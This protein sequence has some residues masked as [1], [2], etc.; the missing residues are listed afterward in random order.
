MTDNRASRSMTAS[1]KEEELAD[2]E[3][4][5]KIVTAWMEG[6]LKEK[7]PQQP[8]REVLLDGVVLCKLANAMKP[9]CIRKYHRRPKMLMMKMENI[10]M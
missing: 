10:G 4:K 8:L 2:L 5:T 1:R 7:L 9:G 3:V 6:L